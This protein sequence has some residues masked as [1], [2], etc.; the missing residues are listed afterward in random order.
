MSNFKSGLPIDLDKMPDPDF[1]GAPDLMEA[2]EGWRAW[3]VSATVPHFGVA[4]KLMSPQHGNYH[5]VPRKEQ[6]AECHKCGENVPG[7]SCGCGFYSA[8]DFDHLMTMSYHLYDLEA[9]M[10][11]VIG[12]VANWGKVIEASLGWRAAKCY[13]VKLFVPYEAWRLAEP[14]SEAYGVP[15]ELK[16]FLKPRKAA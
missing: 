3:K 9:G 16:N 2:V 12:Q 15:V 5:W 8:R 1:V 11:A 13:P 4:P 14:L 10:V 6:L 7:E